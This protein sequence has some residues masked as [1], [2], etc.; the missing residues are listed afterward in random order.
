M[1]TIESFKDCEPFMTLLSWFI[2]ETTR[3]L[4]IS[5]PWQILD[6]SAVFGRYL[7]FMSA[8]LGNSG[9]GPWVIKSCFTP[10]FCTFISRGYLLLFWRSVPS[11]FRSSYSCRNSSWMF[12]L[13]SL[14]NSKRDEFIPSDV[15]WCWLIW[16]AWLP[17]RFWCLWV[18]KNWS[19]CA[20]F[21]CAAI[22]YTC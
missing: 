17:S 20:S 4:K 13:G 6:L 9:A 14:P 19:M 11:I 18:R 7:T 5:I 1:W 2:F 10:I 22:L 8:F 16:C 3:L 12:P 21:V 15:S